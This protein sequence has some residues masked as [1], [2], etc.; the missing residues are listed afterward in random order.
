MSSIPC[1]GLGVPAAVL[2]FACA[3]G[4]AAAAETA[5]TT[6]CATSE[7]VVFACPVRSGK[8]VSVCASRDLDE[9]TGYLQYRFG[10]PG[11]V[12]L[13][14]PAER[15]GSQARFE[16]AHYFRARFELEELRFSNGGHDYVVHYYYNGEERRAAPDIGVSIGKVSL[17]CAGRSINRLSTLEKVVPRGAI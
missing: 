5:Q 9:R 4:L 17:P 11:A 3:S 14:F 8:I 1:G 7:Q 6:H 15:S 12:E 10:R 13:E 2:F 16:Y